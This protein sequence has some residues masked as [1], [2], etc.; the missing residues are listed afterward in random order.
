MIHDWDMHLIT[1]T[2]GL[3]RHQP[4]LKNFDMDISKSNTKFVRN[5]AQMFSG[6][7]FN[8]DL[9]QWD[10]ARVRSMERM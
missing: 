9:S 4:E 3:F 1:T 5:M 10:V 2:A 7:N 6:T 8:G